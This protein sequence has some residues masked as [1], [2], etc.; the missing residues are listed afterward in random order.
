MAPFRSIA[1][2]Q[3]FKEN[4]PESSLCLLGV[5]TED[6]IIYKGEMESVG[7][8]TVYAVSKPTPGFD[9]HHGR[10]TDYL[11]SLPTS[12]VWHTTDFY[13]CGNG[14]MVTEVSNLLRGGY[15]VPEKS[16][17]KEAFSLVLPGRK[18][19]KTTG[20]MLV[21]PLKQVG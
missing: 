11:K 12:W 9:G 3:Q 8:P 18:P 20:E 19:K 6:E 7:I 13:L 4:P 21:N 2:S 17:H 16:I 10:V 14:E 1:F 15:G 5:R